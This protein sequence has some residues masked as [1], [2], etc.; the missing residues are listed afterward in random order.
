MQIQVKPLFIQSFGGINFIEEHLKMFKFANT[1]AAELGSRSALA[2]YSYADLI[3]QLFYICCIGGDTLDESHTLQY[4]MQD[5]PHL[6]FASPDTIEYAFQELRQKSKIEVAA[7]GRYHIINEHKGFNKLL[8]SLCSKT[9]LLASTENYTM[10][11]DG[12]VVKN[13]KNDNAF[14]YKKSEGYYPVICSINKLPVYMQ[15]RNGNTPESYNQ[16]AIIQAAV[17][18]C[19]CHNIAINRFRADAGCY[20]KK[21]VEYLEQQSIIYYI[22]AE[23]STGLLTAL[24]DETEWKDAILNYQKVQVSSIEYSV[25]GRHQTRHIVAYRKKVNGQ[26]Q[27]HQSDGYHY[28]AVLTSDYV[29]DELNVLSLYNQRGC[30]GEHHFKELDYDFNWNKLPFDNMEMNTIYMYATLLGYVLFNACK[31]VFAEKVNFVT[32]AMRL[33][34]F[35]LHFI[36]LPAKWIITARRYVLKLFTQKDYSALCCT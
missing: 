35:I 24:Q 12:H 34:S 32:P 7:S 27:L 30:E 20:E 3:K 11:Y 31:K 29:L 19:R 23:M 22:R 14:T 18:E 1:V 28:H 13:T 33:K 17:E 16:T 6:R 26:L 5:H 8:V 25:F 2:R 9:G 21:L 15:N 4:Q 10:D 36:T